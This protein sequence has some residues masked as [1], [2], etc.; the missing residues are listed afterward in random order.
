MIRE[1]RLKN[2]RVLCALFSGPRQS[3]I[4]PRTSCVLDESRL[5]QKSYLFHNQKKFLIFF[6]SPF[7]KFN[8]VD[9]RGEFLV[10]VVFGRNLSVAML[11][12]S[13]ALVVVQVYSV[14]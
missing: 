3:F 6:S 5:V 4:A 13:D 8:Y 7:V 9:K 1:T 10:E 12:R 11:S 14:H 2:K